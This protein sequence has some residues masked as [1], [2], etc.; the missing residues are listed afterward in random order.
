MGR[1]PSIGGVTL[2]TELPLDRVLAWRVRRQLLHRPGGTD[3]RTV[4]RRL[5]GVQAQVPSSADHAVAARLREPRRGTTGEA[6]TARQLVRTWAM[7]GTLH[8]LAADELGDYLALLAAART[9]E[10]GSWQKNFVTVHQLAAMTDAVQIALDGAVLSREELTAAIVRHAKDDSL[11]EHLRSGWG[12]VLKPLAWQGFLVNGPNDGTRVTF[13]APKDVVPGW[14]G[15]PDADE[16]ASRVVPAYLGAYGPAAPATFDAWLLRNSTPKKRLAG[17]FESTALEKVTVA[18]RPAYA[19]VEDVED[20][21]ATEPDRAVR[22]LDAFDQYVLGPGT[23]NP[24]IL[25]PARRPLVSKAAGWIAPVVLVG[26]RVAGV[27]EVDGDDLAVTAFPEEGPIDEDGLR[28]E[29]ARVSSYLGR[30]LRLTR[31]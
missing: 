20:I 29:S 5:C 27:W 12:A 9:W 21:L 24:E 1:R 3:V 19:R 30:E 15:L 18:G 23:G 22:L 26:G 14:G 2:S 17:W 10:K 28:A 13:A 4:T 8:L 31:R 16:A 6:L 25:E 7:R 11:A